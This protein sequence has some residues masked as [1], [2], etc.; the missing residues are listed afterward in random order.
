MI[1]N[2]FYRLVDWYVI[3]VQLLKGR[4]VIFKDDILIQFSDKQILCRAGIW[5]KLDML[6]RIEESKKNCIN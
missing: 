1:K 6:D 2:L 5:R 4:T 3:I